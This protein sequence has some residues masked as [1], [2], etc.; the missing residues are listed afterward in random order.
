VSEGLTASIIRVIALIVEAVTVSTSETLVN[1]YVPTRH[2]IP[3]TI[4]F[5]LATIRT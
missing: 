3:K 5:T 2:N 4:I 1:F